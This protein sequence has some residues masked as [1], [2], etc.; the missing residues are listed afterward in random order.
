MHF[1]PITTPDGL[2]LHLMFA[3][4]L[5]SA[6]LPRLSGVRAALAASALAG[7]VYFI[8]DGS[9]SGMV[10]TGVILLLTGAQLGRLLLG[11]ARASF[12]PE[13][14]A[15]LHTLDGL[16]RSHVRHLI[17]QGL[18]LNGKA[19][20]TLTE[21]GQAV[22]NLYYLATGGATV[23]SGGKIVATCQ[24][25]NF[26]GEVTA[27]AGSPATGTVTLDRPSRIWCMPAEK[28]RTYASTHD[29]VRA[30]LERAFRKA[31]TDK[32]VAANATI[33]ELSTDPADKSI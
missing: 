24:P 4:L 28:L 17:D 16:S 3:L 8:R 10:W 22:P 18:W 32:L 21:E 25:N 5:L 12:L 9:L 2:L 23:S 6:L 26:V 1:D 20:D 11:D 13:E 31:L 14:Q 33:A 29:G 30:A 15:L 19:G 7:L 27:L